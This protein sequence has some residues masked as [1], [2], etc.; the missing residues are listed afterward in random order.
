MK[1]SH[2]ILK[3]QKYHPID[4]QTLILELI[5][6]ELIVS[7]NFFNGPFLQIKNNSL[8]VSIYSS[9]LLNN[10]SHSLTFSS[11]PPIQFDISYISSFK[12]FNP[13]KSL[14]YSSKNPSTSELFLSLAK[15]LA[16]LPYKHEKE[17]K[18][19]KLI[20]HLYLSRMDQL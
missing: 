5:L 6:D 19:W 3:Y 17:W 7:F 20:S 18:N 13:S 4:H 11:S 14:S 15:S 2:F 9:I 1:R 16:V 12:P 8:L 10:S